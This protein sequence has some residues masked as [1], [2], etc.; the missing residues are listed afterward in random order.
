MHQY[1]CAKCR[2]FLKATDIKCPKCGSTERDILISLLGNV[3]I[4]DSISM[5]IISQHRIWTYITK[6]I[7]YNIKNLSGDPKDI[8][9]SGL[10]LDIIV[11]TASLIE[12]IVT[13]HIVNELEFFLS[14]PLKK[15]KNEKYLKEIHLKA[16]AWKKKILKYLNWNIDQLENFDLIENLFSLRNNIAHG[17]SYNIVET[18]GFKDK[19]LVRSKP[20]A[21]ENENYFKVYRFLVE[22]GIVNDLIFHSVLSVEFFL[23]PAVAEYFYEGSKLFLNDFFRTIKLNSNLNMQPEYERANL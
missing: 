16:W 2:Y 7:Q 3:E 13:D 10:C 6:T 21:I 12:G 23:V 17:K 4:R 8:P 9:V 18:R 11:S 19:V 15:G 22:K 20:V 14:D 1:S 5:S